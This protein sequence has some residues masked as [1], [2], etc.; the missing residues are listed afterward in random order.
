MVES[1]L[2]GYGGGMGEEGLRNYRNIVMFLSRQ[3]HKQPVNLCKCNT[4]ERVLT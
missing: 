2:Y 1:I 4:G 3:E